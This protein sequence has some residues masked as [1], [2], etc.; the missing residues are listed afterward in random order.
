MGAV[1]EVE[2]AHRLSR[3]DLDVGMEAG[4]ETLALV[5]PSGAGKTS[6][7]RSIAGLLAPDRGRIVHEGR[8]LL[9]TAANVS[10][11]LEERRVGM[12]F[13]DGALFPFLSVAGNVVYG[14]RRGGRMHA[15]PGKRIL[16][17]RVAASGRL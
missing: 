14:I 4:R 3:L 6:V 5:G 15:K 10:V 1:L 17:P 12:V 13:Q 11:A 7:L 9:D 8:T 16:N 2:L